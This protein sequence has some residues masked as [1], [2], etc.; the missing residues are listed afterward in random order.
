[1]QR[2]RAMEKKKLPEEMSWKKPKE[3]E[4]LKEEMKPTSKKTKFRRKVIEDEESGCG[5]DEEVI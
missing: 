3:A 5:F 1:M 4:N 2:L